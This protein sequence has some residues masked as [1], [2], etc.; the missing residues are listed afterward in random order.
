MSSMVTGFQNTQFGIGNIQIDESSGKIFSTDIS[1]TTSLLGYT[2]KA[3]T[4]LE[5]IATEALTKSEEYKKKADEYE[6]KLVDAGLIQKPMTQ[7]EQ[8]AT[9]VSM[10]HGLAK[11]V[12]DFGSKLTS[13]QEQV[14]ELSG[15]SPTRKGSLPK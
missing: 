13:M 7:E 14:N 15:T 2:K 11:T 3:F 1:G 4:D 6:T 9:L 12:N 5:K 10:V 8:M